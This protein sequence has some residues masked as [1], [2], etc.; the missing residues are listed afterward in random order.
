MKKFISE[1]FENLKG[2]T[3]SKVEN[4]DN[5]K[6]VFTTIEGEVYELS[7]EQEC[8]ESVTIEDICGDLDDLIGEPLLVVEEVKNGQNINLEGAEDFDEWMSFTWTF[9][10]MD[11]RKGGVTIRFFGESNG[12]YSETVDFYRIINDN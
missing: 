6:L 1:K 4:F 5:E 3:L 12:C 2:K 11:T 7:H 9:Y 10:K 8:C